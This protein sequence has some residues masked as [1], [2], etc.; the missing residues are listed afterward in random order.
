MNHIRINYLTSQKVILFLNLNTFWYT[1][2]VFCE[3][4][5]SNFTGLF[6]ISLTQSQVG[7][8]PQASINIW[9]ITFGS[10]CFVLVIFTGWNVHIYK[11]YQNQNKQW[12]YD[13]EFFAKKEILCSVL[14]ENSSYA[15]SHWLLIYMAHNPLQNNIVVRW[16]GHYTVGGTLMS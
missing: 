2:F 14:L 8:Q 1:H 7:N 6:N 5:R 16:K 3:D 4:I 13:N 10:V 12:I 9:I 11:K 15:I